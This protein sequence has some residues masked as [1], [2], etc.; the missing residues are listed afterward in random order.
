MTDRKLDKT[1]EQWRS[2]LTPEAYQVLRKGGTEPAFS[3][4]LWDDKRPGA[5]RCAGCDTLLF[6]SDTKYDSGSGWP[7]FW[8]PSEES[9]VEIRMDHG[10]G[11]VREE[12]VCA[13]CGGHLGHRFTDGPQPTGQRYCINSA[14]L[15]FD[16][17]P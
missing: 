3:G 13:K 10:H 4:A 1:D 12:A 2:C 16:P 11:M 5:Y 9:A 15:K 14:A 17:A 8:E 7:S 6:E